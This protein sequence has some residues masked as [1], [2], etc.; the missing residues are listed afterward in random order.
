MTNDQFQMTKTLIARFSKLRILPSF[1]I[2]H[3]CFVI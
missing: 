3:L 1:V 2:R